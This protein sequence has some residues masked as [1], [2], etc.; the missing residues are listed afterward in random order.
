MAVIPIDVI[1][2]PTPS[3]KRKINI[4]KN[5]GA[6]RVTMPRFINDMRDILPRQAPLSDTGNSRWS[7]IADERILGENKEGENKGVRFP[8][9]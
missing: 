9:S 5:L 7:I 8:L 6:S 3:R 2:A 4:A 1:T